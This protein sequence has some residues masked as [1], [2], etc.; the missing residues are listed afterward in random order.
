MTFVFT[1]FLCLPAGDNPGR[2]GGHHVLRDGCTLF[3]QFYI[4]YIANHSKYDL[5]GTQCRGL[6]D[7]EVL[8]HRLDSVTLKVFSNLV[9][10]GIL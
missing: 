3:L 4:F 1:L 9:H 8:G 5:G 2:L 6:V 10:S 7:V